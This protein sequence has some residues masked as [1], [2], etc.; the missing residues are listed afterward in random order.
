MTLHPHRQ[1]TPWTLP[2]H[3]HDTTYDLYDLLEED[4]LTRLRDADCMSASDTDD[5]SN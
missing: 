1:N 2:T 5:D 4:A 3:T